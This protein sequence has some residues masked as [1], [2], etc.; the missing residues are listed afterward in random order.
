ARLSRRLRTWTRQWPAR[1]VKVRLG[2]ERD[3]PVLA[4]LA[5]S[6]ASYQGFTPFPQDYLT[7][8]Y[9]GLAVGGHV[10]LLIGELSGAPVAA[11]LMTC[12]G[13]VL[14]S[15]ITGFD[16]S[17]VEAAKLNVASAMIWEAICWGKAN[18]YRYYDFGGLRPESLRAL[19]A[20]GPTELGVLAGPDQFKSKFGGEVFIYPPAVEL[21]KSRAVR[22]G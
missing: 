13:G 10:G 21:I 5:A 12:S 17:S 7:A 14:K 9:Q 6:T 22:L 16:R 11:E 20:A 15:R 8:T 3:I 1:G 4:R 19:R 2:D 18:G